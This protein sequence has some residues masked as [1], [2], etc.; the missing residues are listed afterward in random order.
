MQPASAIAVE[1]N[2]IIRHVLAE[3]A[4]DDIDARIEQRFMR[5]APPRMRFRIRE[6]DDAAVG[7]RRQHIAERA[8]VGR[9]IPA[10]NVRIAGFV[11]E[12]IASGRQRVE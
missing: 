6:I 9:R 8:G 10:E 7:E 5:V 11:G 3:V 1:R 2:G 12:Q 4:F